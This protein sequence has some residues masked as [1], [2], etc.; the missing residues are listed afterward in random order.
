MSTK[1][2]GPTLDL[3]GGGLDLVFP[4]HENEIAQSQGATG[5]TYCRHW[6]HNGFVEVNKTKMGKSLGNFFTARD[7]FD[8][9]EPEAIRFFTMTVHYRSPLNFDWSIDEKGNVTG[10]PQIEA[11]EGRLEYLYKTQA[12]LLA[13]PEGRIREGGPAA[14]KGVHNV[15]GR[16]QEVLDDDLNMPAALA[17]LSDFLGGVNELCDGAL[18]KKGKTS[19]E[20]LAEAQ[21]GFDAI[22]K[23]L[24]LGAGDATT[25]LHRVRDRR[26]AAQGITPEFVESQIAA[27]AA[28]RTA[29]DF[30]ESDRIRD[31]LAAKGVEL[32]DSPEGTTWTMAIE[33]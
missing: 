13:I 20:A 2:L 9:V 26:A 14:P 16:L 17:V 22:A 8:R 21:A 10:F 27:R 32:H 5:E 4:H 15:D 24:G 11:A 7:L 33:A 6:I 30:S 3:H 28:A 12:R 31:E 29:K 1:H 19:P 18:R 23:R 25:I